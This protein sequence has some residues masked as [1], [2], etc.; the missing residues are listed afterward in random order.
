MHECRELQRRVRRDGTSL[1]TARHGY[2]RRVA[3]D[4][5]SRSP[6]IGITQRTHIV[7]GEWLARG[8]NDQPPVLEEVSNQI[9][10]PAGLAG[11]AVNSAR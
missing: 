4:R 10:C 5:G 3:Q 7:I 11:A 2:S 8:T 9:L 6:L 1:S